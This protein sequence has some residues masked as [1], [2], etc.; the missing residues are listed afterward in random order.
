MTFAQ[1]GFTGT[2]QGMTNPQVLQVHML[3][4]DLQAYAGAR[5][6]HHGMCVGADMQFHNMARALKLM[7]VG[8]P[9]VTE[10][11]LRWKRGTMTVTVQHLPKPF[12]KRNLDIVANSDLLIATPHEGTE[13]KR[14]S[15]TWA[16]IRYVLKADKPLII[17]YP[18]GM[19]RAGI[20]GVEVVSADAFRMQLAL[21]CT[22]A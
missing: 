2:W 13:Q 7:T 11:G 16:T 8:Y 22:E 21:D 19:A 9:G 10:S 3:L 4:G 12:L 15:G 6:V 20:E 18:D 5:C 17:V 14:G 1:I